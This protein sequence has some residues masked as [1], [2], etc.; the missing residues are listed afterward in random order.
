M[1]MTPEYLA[2][3]Q[4]NIAEKGEDQS[5][6]QKGGTFVAETPAAGRCMLRL[7]GYIE[8]G[9]HAEEFTEAGKTTKK[10]PNKVMLEFE[11]RGAAWPAENEETGRKL[12]FVIRDTLTLS[13]SDRANYHKLFHQMRGGDETITHMT[14]LL[15]KPF[16]GEITHNKSKKDEKKVYANLKSKMEGYSIRPAYKE[17]TDF[18]TGKVTRT[19]IKVPEAINPIRAFVWDFADKE[20]WDAIFIDGVSK[21]KTDEAGNEI[22][23]GRSLNWIQN[24]IKKALNFKGSPAHAIAAGAGELDLDEP[25][26]P[27]RSEQ[28]D[29]DQLAAQFGGQKQA[30]KESYDLNDD[31]PF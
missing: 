10:T 30:P 18:E 8:L 2:K 4:A 13:N 16:I 6:T 25:E 1:A 7:V 3:L 24:I 23:P 19:P 29:E 28:S 12:P 5:E 17:E 21:P 15:G 27:N 11:V 22:E 9:Q 20:Q 31:I 14:Q 26:R